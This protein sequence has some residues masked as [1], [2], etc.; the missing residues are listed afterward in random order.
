MTTVCC[1]CSQ[2]TALLHHVHDLRL[3]FWEHFSEA[4]SAL[5]EIVLCRT[6]EAT[7]N[8]LLRVVDLGSEGK[9]LASLFGDGD[10]V[11][12]QHIDGNTELL[13]LDNGLGGIFTRWIEHRKH[14]E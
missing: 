7:I 6:R 8:E 11:T 2:V 9:H 1:H 5:H 13:S 10:G 3:V 12:S 4:I 14:T